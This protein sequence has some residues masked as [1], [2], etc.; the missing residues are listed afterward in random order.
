M[1]FLSGEVEQTM[2]IDKSAATY[3]DDSFHKLVRD[4]SAVLGPS[5]GI[6]SDDVDPV[7]LQDLM[8]EYT[9][10]E[11]QWSQYALSDSSIGYTRNLVDK[12][13]GK[14]NLVSS[15]KLVSLEQRLI[16]SS[17]CWSGRQ[18]KEVQS[19]TMQMPTV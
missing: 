5:S 14:S 6:D 13:N 7:K 18:V 4:L 8:K 9:S 19:M 17:L 3:H 10:D 11:S 15:S 2:P 12:G 1:P 16:I